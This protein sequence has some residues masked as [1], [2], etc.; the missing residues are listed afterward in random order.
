M[1]RLDRR[2]RSARR[3]RRGG[4]RTGARRRARPRG[5]R[6]RRSTCRDGSPRHPSA[7]GLRTGGRV[8]SDERHPPDPPSRRPLAGR[9]PGSGHDDDAGAARRPA[10]RRRRR[11]RGVGPGQCA[12]RASPR[13]G[14]RR[15]PAQ[16]HDAGRGALG[17]GRWTIAEEHLASQT[18]T[19]APRADPRRRRA[20]RA[21]SGRSPSW[22]ASP[23]SIT[24]IGLVCLDQVLGDEGWTVAN[25]GPDVPAA[26]LARFL[27]R[28][29]AELVALTASLPGARRGA[30]GVGR[31]RPGRCDPRIRSRSWSGATLAD[32]D[33]AGPVARRRLG[34]EPRWQRPPRTPPTVLERARGPRPGR[35]ARAPLTGA[36]DA[37]GADHSYA[38]TAPWSWA[39]STSAATTTCDTVPSAEPQTTIAWRELP[40]TTSIRQ[41][42]RPSISSVVARTASVRAG[43]VGGA[44]VLLGQQ[45]RREPVALEGAELDARRARRPP[46]SRRRTA[47]RSTPASKTEPS[48][49]C[50]AE[51]ARIAAGGPRLRR[52]APGFAPRGPGRR[53]SSAARAGRVA[54]RRR[55]E[56]GGGRGRARRRASES[57]GHD[58]ARAA[59]RARRRR[60]VRRER[61]VRM[62]RSLP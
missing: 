40:L 29:Q 2:R 46:R 61:G 11:A 24:A 41:A 45:R 16:R 55:I 43:R 48:V 7:N 18:I 25:L 15:P 27:A 58:A 36:A 13:R 1:G 12:P 53:P 28:N 14:L 30:P 54:R 20:R 4:P 33:G 47:P 51:A 52:S 42:G 19:R 39:S 31:G 5:R 60:I 50:R 26:D 17:E 34:R 59:A 49:S 22:R 6:G 38:D 37:R 10:R 44:A 35:G 32:D 56:G 21:A 3:A 23:A 8:R 57:R 62:R 9:R